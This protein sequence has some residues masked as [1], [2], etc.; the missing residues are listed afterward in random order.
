M[1]L[2]HG[3]VIV[4]PLPL[5]DQPVGRPE[6]QS[7][8]ISAAGES[9]VLADGITSLRHLV[10]VGLVP[11][12]ARGNHYHKL[13]HESFYVVA[14]ELVLHLRDVATG[15]QTSV[16]MRAGDLAYLEPNIVHTFLPTAP[17]HA[18]EFAPEVFDAQ[19]VYRLVIA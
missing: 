11:G 9:A 4:R 10:Y 1:T 5:T 19:D 12:K 17:G 7:R 15:E 13:R 14:G 8:L 18:V 3:K 6:V 16:T 2:L